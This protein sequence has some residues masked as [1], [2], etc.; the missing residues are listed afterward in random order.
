VI[1]VSLP[2]GPS[3]VP[4]RV[5]ADPRDRDRLRL[6]FPPSLARRLLGL[7]LAAPASAAVLAGA[8][9]EAG[10]VVAALACAG[11]AAL[12]AFGRA[13]LVLDRRR[14]RVETAWGAPLVFARFLE[15][16]GPFGPV[17]VSQVEE[18]R[19]RDGSASS[20]TRY[21]VAVRAAGGPARLRSFPTWEAAL[22]F[23]EVVARF[24]GVGLQDD[25]TRRTLPA[26][27]LDEPLARSAAREALAS[28][29]RR[30]L[31]DVRWN[32][33]DELVVEVPRPG[34]S[35]ARKFLGLLAVVAFLWTPLALCAGAVVEAVLPLVLVAAAGVKVCWGYGATVV[36]NDRGL[37]VRSRGL[38]LRRALHIPLAELEGLALLQPESGGAR[39]LLAWFFPGVLVA[40][41]DRA[42]A[43]FGHGLAR[44]DL[45][46]IRDEIV[47]LLVRLG[48]TRE[49]ALPPREAPAAPGPVAVVLATW[50]ACGLAGAWLGPPASVCLGLPI[51][52]AW[53]SVLGLS[54]ALVARWLTRRAAPPAGRTMALRLAALALGLWLGLDLFPGWVAARPDLDLSAFRSAI[55][56]PP[57]P[58]APAWWLGGLSGPQAASFYLL[59]LVA[60]L[61]GAWAVAA[62]VVPPV[63]A[64]VARSRHRP[65]TLLPLLPPRDGVAPE[66]PPPSPAG[67]RR[68]A[69]AV[70]AALL[71]LWSAAS[72]PD[73]WRPRSLAREQ[74]LGRA[75][76][77]AARRAREER[78]RAAVTRRLLRLEMP[79]PGAW[80]RGHPA[81]WYFVPYLGESAAFVEHLLWLRLAYAHAGLQVTGFPSDV[82]GDRLAT[83]LEERGWYGVHAAD[84]AAAAA[85]RAWS[86]FPRDG[87]Y[88]LLLEAD[89]T[90]RDRLALPGETEARL[91]AWLGPP[92]VPRPARAP[93]PVELR[94]TYAGHPAPLPAEGSMTVLAHDAWSFSHVR[95]FDRR[96]SLPREALP[97]SVQSGV[98]RVRVQVT[99][100][101]G[102]RWT[103]AFDGWALVPLSAAGSGQRVVEIPLLVPLKIV[104]PAGAGSEDRPAYPAAQPLTLAWTPA[105]EADRYTVTIRS[106]EPTEESPPRQETVPGER[107]RL[108]LDD[109]P[110]GGYEVAI[111]AWRGEVRL[112]VVET[113]QG[114]AWRPAF[115]FALVR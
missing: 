66:F 2:L 40:R 107:S 47:R 17:S 87:A 95:W 103:P 23:A 83:L 57:D 80:A 93:V 79:P 69:L 32:G 8:R 52:S 77:E 15:A 51:L 35:L 31:P 30:P 59:V 12:V 25:V 10:L 39:G 75:A 84:A 5:V 54:G 62:I 98:W 90:V 24:L 3:E 92:A 53:L 27:G 33:E 21:P 81:L 49:L 42:S 4:Y 26:G 94:G 60:G 78:E 106:L 55:A 73:T 61:A 86:G 65:S 7:L 113:E 38:L 115:R 37:T 58:G 105:P 46:A 70:A 91:A 36:A 71:L 99:A 100:R 28:G 45:L 114:G 41:S 48:H 74:A 63:T 20:E 89:G 67:R 9:E 110:P 43:R 16:R 101:S 1:S 19:G 22:D 88:A 34:K 111:E 112:G 29:G 96:G 97:L 108:T 109:L 56:K 44:R 6:V 64:V 104:A 50:F 72:F 18:T 68:E 11:G 14:E 13:T 76:A 82:D 85:Y 102:D